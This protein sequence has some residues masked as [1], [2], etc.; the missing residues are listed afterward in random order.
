VYEKI[1][2]K[3]ENWA[4]LLLTSTVVDSPAKAGGTAQ[5]MRVDV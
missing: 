3:S 5:L 1:V 2:P 4:P